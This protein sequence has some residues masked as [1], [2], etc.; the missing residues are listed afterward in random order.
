MGFTR[1]GAFFGFFLLIER[2]KTKLP[3]QNWKEKNEN[4]TASN[5]E[6][7]YSLCQCFYKSKK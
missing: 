7:F 4:L 2:S 5:G 3:D 6:S 1:D